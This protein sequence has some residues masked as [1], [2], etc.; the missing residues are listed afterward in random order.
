[1]KNLKLH[2][3]E[4]Y[5]T[6]QFR[7]SHENLYIKPLSKQKI[8][9]QIYDKPYINVYKSPKSIQENGNPTSKKCNMEFVDNKHTMKI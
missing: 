4:R 8:T 1:M 2:V 3:H 9:F 5:V 6:L 7:K